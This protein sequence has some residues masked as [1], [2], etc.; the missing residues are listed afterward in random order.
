M[1]RKGVREGLKV[2][3]SDGTSL[4][5]V[6]SCGVDTFVIEKGFF[7]PKDFTARYDQVADLRSDELWLSEPGDQ[8]RSSMGREPARATADQ[9][10]ARSGISGATEEMRVPLAEEE[11]TAQKRT[12]Q[13]GEVR[14]H[15]DVTV[16]NK[17]IEV[18]VTKEEVHVERVPVSPETEARDAQFKEGTVS[19]P[20]YEEEVEIRKRPVVREEV[21]VSK[22]S[23]EEEARFA[24]ETRKETAEVEEKGNLHKSGSLDPNERKT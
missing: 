9:E 11:L 5:K 1:D 19:V 2:R 23:H 8:L 14:I 18:P 10:P 12:A 16:E 3:S 20:V 21:R 4:G 13:A 22:T 17:Q 15:K 6:V 7:F 24:A